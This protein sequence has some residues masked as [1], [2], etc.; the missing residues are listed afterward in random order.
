MTKTKEI[1]S[2]FDKKLE[3]A[4]KKTMSYWKKL[5]A[6][7]TAFVFE[8]SLKMY[9]TKDLNIK[10]KPTFFLC[11]PKN[12]GMADASYDEKAPKMLIACHLLKKDMN[13]DK[14]VLKALNAIQKELNHNID[15]IKQKF[16]EERKAQLNNG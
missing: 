9:E 10:D 7:G 5:R 12:R 11:L 2:K 4:A 1:S 6:E 16:I 13:N 15:H 3:K 14:K 8:T